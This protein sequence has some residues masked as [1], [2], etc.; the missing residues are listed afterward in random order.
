[1][2]YLSDITPNIECET[3]GI[4]IVN[5]WVKST[6]NTEKHGLQYCVVRLAAT[7]LDTYKKV[8]I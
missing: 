8:N 6:C 2:R 5:K 7:I 4:D 3:E 1:M